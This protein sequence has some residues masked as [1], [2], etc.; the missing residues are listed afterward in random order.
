MYRLNQAILKPECV[1]GRRP[2]PWILALLYLL[3]LCDVF[4]IHWFSA[5]LPYCYIFFLVTFIM[6]QSLSADLIL[7]WF[8]W[9]ITLWSLSEY[10]DCVKSISDVFIFYPVLL[11]IFSLAHL[12]PYL[13]WM[14]VLFLCLGPKSGTGNTKLYTKYNHFL[15]TTKCF[16]IWVI[17]YTNLL[18]YGLFFL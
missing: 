7:F 17:W 9:G 8:W 5:I 10:D 14:L 16:N 15:F 6:L 13:Y 3:S 11:N 4:F 18:D 1:L 2:F 12:S